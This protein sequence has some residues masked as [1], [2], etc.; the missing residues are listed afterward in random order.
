[1]MD[2]GRWSIDEAVVLDAAAVRQLERELPEGSGAAVRRKGGAGRGKGNLPMI[3]VRLQ[4]IVIHDTKKWF[5]EADIRLDALVVH[6]N[7]AA[8]KPATSYMPQTFRFPRVS[9]GDR[10]STGEAGL[11]IYYGRVRHFLDLFIMVSRDRK[12]SGDLANLLT[13]QFGSPE[14]QGAIGTLLGLAI[15][16]PQVAT[17]TAAIGAAAAVGNFSYQVLSKATGAT[18]GLYRT[19]WLEHR[20][21]FGIGNH[22]QNGD[23]FREKDLSFRYEVVL[24]KRSMRT[25]SRPQQGAPS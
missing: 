22:P 1:M 9:D 13:K 21:N 12:D 8:G 19:S 25:R 5:G 4:D 7:G 17:I 3:A 6:G 11:L 14:L 15:A 24:E 10:L 23:A 2:E 18:V 20:D 16:A